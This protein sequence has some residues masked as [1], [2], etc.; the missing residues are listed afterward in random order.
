MIKEMVSIN[1]Y[2]DIFAPGTEPRHLIILMLRHVTICSSNY[3]QMIILSRYRDAILGSG[4]LW[5]EESISG[6]NF[7]CLC[8]DPSG[9]A[10]SPVRGWRRE[11]C[12]SNQLNIK[13][14]SL[15]SCP[16]LCSIRHFVRPLTTVRARFAFCLNI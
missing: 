13:T 9:Y 4:I 16:L 1:L 11:I 7:L 14:M 6:D 3:Y 15:L 2:E 5:L 12:H 10:P 8:P